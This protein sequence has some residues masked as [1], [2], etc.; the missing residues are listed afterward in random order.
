MRIIYLLIL[1][2]AFN[3]AFSIATFLDGY[4][5]L[6]LFEFSFVFLKK[7]YIITY[8]PMTVAIGLCIIGFLALVVDKHFGVQ[9]RFFLSNLRLY[10]PYYIPAL[11]FSLLAYIYGM[12]FAEYIELD[13]DD[14]EQWSFVFN[15][16][17]YT[18]IWMGF[19]SVTKFILIGFFF[20]FLIF[21]YRN[22]FKIN[23]FIFF[24]KTFYHFLKNYFFKK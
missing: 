3:E 13:Y 15:N 19:D 17:R 10:L 4:L 7:E 12:L 21:F 18:V 11:L 8:H 22:R 24:L 1:V 2:G 23:F 5:D 20:L 9:I 16:Y 14:D 6:E